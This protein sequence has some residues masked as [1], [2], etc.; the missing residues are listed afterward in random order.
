MLDEARLRARVDRRRA[1]TLVERLRNL[2]Q[3]L[4]ELKPLLR[5]GYAVTRQA[6]GGARGWRHGREDAAHLREGG[7]A[8]R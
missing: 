5:V 2:S 3:V 4:P 8:Q 6:A 1:R 7:A